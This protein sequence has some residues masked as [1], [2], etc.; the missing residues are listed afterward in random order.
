M[1]VVVETYLMIQETI[2]FYK[3]SNEIL[4]SLAAVHV[5]WYGASKITDSVNII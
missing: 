5:Q 3:L 2:E 4:R 1:E